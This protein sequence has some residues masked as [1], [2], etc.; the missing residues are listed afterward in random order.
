MAH[1]ARESWPTCAIWWWPRSARS[2][3]TCSISPTKRRATSRRSPQRATPT[4]SVG[5]HHGFSRAF[6]DIVRSAPAPRRARDGARAA[7]ATAAARSPRRSGGAP[8]RS[9]AAAF[10]RAARPAG[11]PSRLEPSRWQGLPVA[12]PSRSPR[13]DQRLAPSSAPAGRPRV[14]P[15]SC[16]ASPASLDLR[17]R[18]ASPRPSTSPTFLPLAPAPIYPLPLRLHPT[19]PAIHRPRP[20]LSPAPHSSLP[21]PS[22]PRA[23]PARSTSTLGAPSS[24]ASAPSAR[25][26]P[27]C[28][29]TR[30]PSPSAPSGSC[31][32][33][34]AQLV[35]GGAGHRGRTRSSSYASGARL[36]R[37]HNAGRV[38]PHRRPQV[39]P[40]DRRPRQ[41][42]ATRP[43]RSKR[44]ARW[45]STR[46]YKAAIDILG[47]ELR[48]VRVIPE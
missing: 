3:A 18:S 24:S 26:S 15:T 29:S 41:R 17:E 34:E 8:R 48:D 47:A 45:P 6:D 7:R 28:S 2:R 43:T 31:S 30:R 11:A 46:S 16:L 27:R 13:R 25:P 1:V 4:I 32:G 44:G 35:L 10:R 36:L 9:R 38:R 5:L 39:G 21:S 23:R 12:P 33:Y 37:R 19:P 22:T 14:T 20:A 40:L 42:R